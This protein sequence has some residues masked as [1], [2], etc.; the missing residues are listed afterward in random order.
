MPDQLRYSG[1]PVPTGPEAHVV[2]AD[3]KS[4]GDAIDQSLVL[5]A[6]SIADRDARYGNANPPVLPGTLVM[7]PDTLW[8]R[9][10]S[11]GWDTVWSSAAPQ[12]WTP[13]RVTNDGTETVLQTV[14][15]SL[16]GV[17]SLEGRRV[18][19]SVKFVFN[20]SNIG[21]GNPADGTGMWRWTLP[22]P[23]AQWWQVWGTGRFSQ[24]AAMLII[25]PTAATYVYLKIAHTSETL[26]RAQTWS[27]GDEVC[28][29]GSY[30]RA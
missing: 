19:F 4:F 6:S 30:W 29:S 13:Q 25:R 11:S 1:A 23:A 12:A 8:R 7:G 14:N 27:N 15:G 28:F 18:D 17:W 26:G 10:S 2:P 9:N 22:V 16:E 3:F 5:P 21:G 20:N 24:S